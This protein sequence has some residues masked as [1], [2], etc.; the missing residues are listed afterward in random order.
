M[1]HYREEISIEITK[2]FYSGLCLFVL[3]RQKFS[4]AIL[5]MNWAIVQLGQRQLKIPS[6]KATFFHLWW[7]FENK[8]ADF[9]HKYFATEQYLIY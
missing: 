4:L 2:I 7:T 6:Y 8:Y 3:I 9:M 1:A 5:K